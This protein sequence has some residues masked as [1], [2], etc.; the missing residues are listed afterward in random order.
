MTK[1]AYLFVTPQSVLFDQPLP[2][3]SGAL[4]HSIKIKHWEMSQCC[5]SSF[6]IKSSE[7]QI[8]KKQVVH[9]NKL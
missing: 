6:T 7:G 8:F 1:L 5:S 4:E 9:K 3:V 2:T